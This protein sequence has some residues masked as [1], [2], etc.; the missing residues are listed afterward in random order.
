M[1]QYFILLLHSSTQACSVRV[2]VRFKPNSDLAQPS[3]YRWRGARLLL[4]PPT[5]SNSAPAFRR[6]R[7][8]LSTTGAWLFLSRSL[9]SNFPP[10]AVQCA[11]CTPKP[12]P[13][14][15]LP[16]LTFPHDPREQRSRRSSGAIL[17]RYRALPC[18][19]AAASV[20][21]PTLRRPHLF[22]AYSRFNSACDGLA[23]DVLSGRNVKHLRASPALARVS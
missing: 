16:P 5:S 19:H 2:L 7:P 12:P 11:S 13:S 23:D 3:I 4:P 18:C 8:S 21:P 22:H 1:Y 6:P 10:L 15:P 14:P 9:C 17:F 20:P